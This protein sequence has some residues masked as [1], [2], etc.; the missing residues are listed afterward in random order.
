M[1]PLSKIAD[2][3]IH[4]CAS[5]STETPAQ[6][7]SELV[8]KNIS[9]ASLTDHNTIANQNEF[10]SLAKSNSISAIPGVEISS[11]IGNMVYHILTYGFNPD[12][13]RISE[14]I[15]PLLLMMRDNGRKIIKKM[16]PDYPSLSLSEYDN[17]EHD[18]TLG[19]WK[20]IH[21]PRTPVSLDVG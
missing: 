8:Q 3:H 21:Y 20:F 19:G 6:I 7:I 4:S 2:L 15:D 11:K 10:L 16:L 13:R 18:C 12:D 14:Y 5:D 17:Y 9:I 1:I